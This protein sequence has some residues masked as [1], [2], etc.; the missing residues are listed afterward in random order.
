MTTLGLFGERAGTVLFSFSRF[1]CFSSDKH[2][3]NYS[4]EFICK[5][6]L[7]FPGGQFHKHACQGLEGF[8]LLEL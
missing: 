7:P 5:V 3:P 8:L 1:I 4:A 6:E 2:S